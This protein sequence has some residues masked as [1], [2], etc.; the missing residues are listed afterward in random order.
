MEIK[1]VELG[2]FSNYIQVYDTNEDVVFGSDPLKDF[3]DLQ[4]AL[5]GLEVD[6]ETGQILNWEPAKQI[7]KEFFD[8]DDDDDDEDLYLL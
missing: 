3:F 5:D 1:K 4:P 7:L 8:D 6:F 2:V